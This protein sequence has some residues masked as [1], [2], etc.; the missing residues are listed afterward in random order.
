MSYSSS[1][2]LPFSH[3]LAIILV[4]INFVFNVSFPQ[5]AEAK[6]AVEANHLPLAGD[7]EPRRVAKIVLT[8]YSSTPGQTDNTPFITANGLTVYDG[9][10]AANWLPLGTR[11]RIP[12]LFGDK[13]FTVNDRMHPRFGAGRV[14]LW[15]DAPIDEVKEFG[16]KRVAMEVY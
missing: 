11:V 15:L 8:A 1:I 9:L 4:L 12:E 6:T 14:D 3:R 13:I 16:V 5:M 7:R 10:V 2:K